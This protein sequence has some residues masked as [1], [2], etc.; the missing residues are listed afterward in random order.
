[1]TITP[2]FAFCGFPVIGRLPNGV[3]FISEGHHWRQC[4]NIVTPGCAYCTFHANGKIDDAPLTE[5]TMID[6]AERRRERWQT[7]SQWI[8]LHL[9]I[10]LVC[11]M[12]ILEPF[13]SWLHV[14]VQFCF[15][16][17]AGSAAQAI[18]WAAWRWRKGDRP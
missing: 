8:R 6:R 2:K 4:G 1:M 5:E 9:V 11:V 10:A 17:V 16:A 14:H 13:H 3:E 15:G 12:A 18:A 7:F